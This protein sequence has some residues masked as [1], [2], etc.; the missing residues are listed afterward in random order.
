MKLAGFPRDPQPYTLDGTRGPRVSHAGAE[1]MAASPARC[2]RE[3]WVSFRGARLWET[4][5]IASVT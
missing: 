4:F 3:V 2:G 5:R 1:T